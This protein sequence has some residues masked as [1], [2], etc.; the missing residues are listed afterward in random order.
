M[1]ILLHPH[2]TCVW[3][4]FLI[5]SGTRVRTFKPSTEA[6]QVV[7]ECTNHLHHV[8]HSEI[9]IS[10]FWWL[11]SPSPLVISWS[12][13]PLITC[14][15]Q[16]SQFMTIRSGVPLKSAMM[17]HMVLSKTS[18]RSWKTFCSGFRPN[19]RLITG[20][21]QHLM[22]SHILLLLNICP[23]HSRGNYNR[24]FALHKLHFFGDIHSRTTFS[25]VS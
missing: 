25:C 6:F 13:W 11:N 12:S 4:D 3:G 20:L 8:H 16:R 2:V 9:T 15:P 1:S 23:L 17:T 22:V 7:G 24:L 18:L 5:G 21:V 19:H 14:F 10:I